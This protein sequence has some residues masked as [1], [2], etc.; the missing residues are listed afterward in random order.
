[1]RSARRLA[2]PAIAWILTAP[3]TTMALAQEPQ[4]GTPDP[5]PPTALEQ[6]LIERICSATSIEAH[7]VCLSSQLN[8]LRA[9]FGRDLTRLS[10]S[11]RR[12]LDSVC[13]RIRTEQGREAYLDCLRTQ[14]GAMR[15]SRRPATKP[16]APDAPALPPASTSE[17]SPS[18]A[19]PASSLSAVR[20]AAAL[21]T[22]FVAAGGALLAVK[23]R[24]AAPR[25]RGGGPSKCRFCGEEV[26]EAGDLCQKCRRE[27]ADALRRAAAER[28]DHERAL[29][30]E[31]LRR[32][33]DEEEQRRQ[34]AQQEEEA[35]LQLVEDA[36]QRA[37][38]ARQRE[39]EE[40]RQRS[41]AAVVVEEVFDPYAV[42]DLP[43]GASREAIDAAYLEAR[44]KY[45]QD[46][47]SHLGMDL[48]EHFKLKAK[49]VERAYQMLTE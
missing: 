10:S 3:L 6:A 27:A 14:L 18:P 32:R 11:E 24:R 45:D 49:A 35:R 40:A 39:E 41:Q 4:V 7:Q 29:Q 9:D 28:A 22:L 23:A 47:V 48:Q 38:T 46:N 2:V 33:E 26:R 15:N 42:L 8:S 30:E 44:A 17:P 31:P 21:V 43:K 13:N 5:A 16:A 37:E 34:K 12:T 1:M 20:I 19:P 36:R 25:D